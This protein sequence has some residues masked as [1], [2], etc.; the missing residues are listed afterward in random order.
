MVSYSRCL[1]WKSGTSPKKRISKSC[2]GDDSGKM[3][4]VLRVGLKS[5]GHS[6]G[7]PWADT[8]A[9]CVGP[10]SLAPTLGQL[11]STPVLVLLG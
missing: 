9:A 3:T 11:T 10:A 1:S 6:R 4:R 5:K 8:L 2:V 7:R